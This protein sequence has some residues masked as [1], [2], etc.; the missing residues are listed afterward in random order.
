VGAEVEGVVNE[1]DRFVRHMLEAVDAWEA[2]EQT[3]AEVLGAY[4][5]REGPGYV[6][7]TKA[8]HD[9]RAVKAA[10]DGAWHRDRARTWALA[11][12]TLMLAEE[13]N[14]P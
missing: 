3:Y 9:A 1:I 13:R 6:A 11:A 14:A 8:S 4:R 5:E 10:A 7:D 12:I 2:S